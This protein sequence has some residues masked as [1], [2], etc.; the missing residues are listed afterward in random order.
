M[1]TPSTRL[2]LQ[3]ILERIGSDQPV[4]LQERIYVQKF[5][6]RDQGVA[7]WLLKARRRQLQ[8][9]PQDSLA[10]DGIDHLLE[11]MNLGPADPDA[12]YRPGED[13]IEGWFGGAP[14]WV[15]RS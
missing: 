10:R 7:A 11:Q 3:E 15:R 8:H 1:L 5:A 14:G 9:L 2:R 6:D 13:D 4:S 12:N